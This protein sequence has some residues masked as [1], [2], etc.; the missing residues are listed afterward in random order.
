MSLSH[1]PKIVTDG[2][3]F[4]YDMDNTKKS[5]NGKPTTNLFGDPLDY[6][7]GLGNGYWEVI[8]NNTNYI[9]LSSTYTSWC[10]KFNCS[11]VASTE[12]T[13][14]FE[15]YTDISGTQLIIDNDGVDERL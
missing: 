10:V 8:D 15:Y 3:A 13:V 7:T 6:N 14:S 4:A 5:W 12:Y 11:L 9:K 2:L 1:S